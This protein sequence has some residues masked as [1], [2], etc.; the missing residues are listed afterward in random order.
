[1]AGFKLPIFLSTDRFH[2]MQ[3]LWSSIL[4]PI[5]TNPVMN[6][7]TLE[8]VKLASGSNVINHTLGRTQQGW[9]LVD[10]NSTATV[11]RSAPFNDLTLTLTASAACTVNI[12]VF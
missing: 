4:N 8:G 5:I 7:L 12:Y 2:S 6:G 11:Y 1:M 10:Q 3:T 9:F